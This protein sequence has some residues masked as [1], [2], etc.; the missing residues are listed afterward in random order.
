MVSQDIQDS[1][2]V[3]LQLMHDHGRKSPSDIV[4]SVRETQGELL[5]IFNSVDEP[6]ALATP[7]ADEWSLRDLALHAVFTER[8]IGKLIHYTARGSVP[9]REDLEGAGIGMMPAPDDRPYAEVL[10]DLATMNAALLDAVRNLP[11]QPD[12]E[13]QV[14]HPF[15]GPLN[16]LEWAGFQRVHD[17]DHIQ[18]AR[19]IIVAINAAR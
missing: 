4:A 16:C 3:Y 1:R 18:H 7:A 10:A 5:A 17:T 12:L 14:P 8:L 11:E 13:M 2:D 6:R 19:K 15:F 9:P